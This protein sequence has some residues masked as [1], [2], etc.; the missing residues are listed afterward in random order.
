MQPVQE[1]FDIVITSNSG[2]PLDLNLYQAI[3]G[4]SAAAQVVKSGGAIIIAGSGMCNG[5]RI[6]HHLKHNLDREETQVLITET[7]ADTDLSNE[8][9]DVDLEACVPGAVLGS[10]PGVS[11]PVFV[12]ESRRGSGGLPVISE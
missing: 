7:G 6:I 10:I 8:V 9:T 1:A 2:Y 12:E 4:V 5:G 3:K 11:R